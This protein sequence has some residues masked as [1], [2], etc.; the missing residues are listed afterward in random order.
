MKKYIDKKLM[1]IV[2]GLFLI[3]VIGAFFVIDESMAE[4]VMRD[5]LD[6]SKEILNEEGDLRLFPLFLDNVKGTIHCL[7]YGFIPFICIPLI[8]SVINGIL[9]GTVLKL[10]YLKGASPFR[11]LFLKVLPHGIFEFPAFF[12]SIGLGVSLCRIISKKIL[13]KPATS[14][15]EFM[16]EAILIYVK[17]VIPLL[18]VAAVI[19]TYV[20]PLL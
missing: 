9:I 20:V 11:T 4:R 18:A 10:S 2:G 7:I 17:T 3:G 19:E 6:S 8:F 16:R 13:R 15:R 14:V 12:I 5:F 1:T